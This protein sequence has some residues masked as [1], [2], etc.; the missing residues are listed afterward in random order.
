MSGLNFALAASAKAP[1]IG[2]SSDNVLKKMGLLYS[3][4]LRI[5]MC[6]S[7]KV[8]NS[9]H[10]EA[11]VAVPSCFTHANPIP[12]LLPN[13]LDVDPIPPV[14]PDLRIGGPAGVAYQNDKGREMYH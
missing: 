3:S 5:G 1:I 2:G 7:I 6:Q 9:L 13:V 10:T 4:N 12:S 8:W 14:A 11:M